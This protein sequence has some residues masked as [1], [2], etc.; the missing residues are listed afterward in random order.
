MS[1]RL[2]KD[3]ENEAPSPGP[4][5]ARGEGAKFIPPPLTGGGKGEGELWGF[6]DEPP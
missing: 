2:T 4:S 6:S 3:D 5:P 1:L